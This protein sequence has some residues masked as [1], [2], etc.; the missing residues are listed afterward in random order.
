M[1]RRLKEIRNR[2]GINQG[3]F[4]KG[5]R[6]SQAQ[7]SAIEHGKQNLTD[8]NIKVICMVYR[9]NEDWLR[10][11]EG[12]M[13]APLELGN[14]EENDINSL[15]LDEK[16]FLLDYRLLTEPN[17]KVA[18]TMVKSLLASQAET[19]ANGQTPKQAPE[20]LPPSPEPDFPLVPRYHVP[21]P[22]PDSAP[23]SAGIEED[24]AAG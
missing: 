8:R 11:G 5:L 12:E 21:P 18:K 13:F 15:P 2:L 7:L 4:S 24:E 16:V 9:V 19:E 22:A 6:I 10:T 3:E 1:N 20:F 23:A 17:K 14:V